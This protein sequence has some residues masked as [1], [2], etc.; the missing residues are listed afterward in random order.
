M[1]LFIT[2]FLWLIASLNNVWAAQQ[3]HSIILA[4]GPLEINLT[5]SMQWLETN[6]RNFSLGQLQIDG[7]P[8]FNNLTKS[9]VMT[10]KTSYWLR[11]HIINPLNQI[12]PVALSLSSNHVFI[13]GAYLYRDNQW[14][15]LVGFEKKTRLAGHTAITLNIQSHSNQWIYLRV[16]SPQSS[17]LDPKL[18]D[19]SHYNLSLSSLQQI[20]GGIIAFMLFIAL[21]HVIAIRFHNHIRHYLIIYIA[22][23]NGTYGLS[24]LPL[25]QWNNWF[26]LVCNLAPWTLACGLLLSSF[27]TH[28][29]RDWLKTNRTLFMLLGMSLVSL[30][31]FN[32]PQ[33]FVLFSS[34]IAAISAF[35]LSLKVS[36]NLSISIGIFTSYMAWQCLSFLFPQTLSPPDE[37]LHSYAFSICIMFCSTSMILP[38]FKRQIRK[39]IPNNNSQQSEFLA[40]LSH[41]LRSPM[42]GVLG[43]SELL[44]DTP[45]SHSQRDYVETIQVSGQ[46]ILRLINRISDFS[47]ISQGN[48]VLDEAPLN[49]STLLDGCTNKFAY[50]A[51]QK[52]IELIL[53]Q[54]PDIPPFILADERRLQT[55]IENLLENALLHTH[56][57]EIELRIDFDKQQQHF[58]LFS[59]RDTGNGI[60]K[61][62]LK[63]LFSS[64]DNLQADKSNLQNSGFILALCKRLVSLMGG[65]MYIDSKMGVGSTFSFSIPLK[66]AKAEKIQIQPKSQHQILNGLSMLVVDDNSTLRKVIQRYGKSWGMQIDSTYSG[67]EA[68]AMLRSK[69]NVGQAYDIILID[70][71]MPIMDGLQLAKRIQEDSEIDQGLLKIM[72]T[73]L[74]INS[75]NSDVIQSG[76]Q[77]V[78]NKP[79]SVHALQATLSEHISRQRRLKN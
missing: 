75:H 3:Q 77:Q 54:A 14:Q 59:I 37:M 42:N 50:N 66:Q 71:N 72:L 4:D 47:T 26:L 56:H 43:M 67:K 1:R 15:R 68:L 40:H 2:I 5:N 30:L 32:A 58:L 61:E 25:E 28:A 27:T 62:T 52:S 65:H 55:I 41:E 8:L 6:H 45:L 13:E 70:Q 11:F 44:N 79:V 46:D 24:N 33:E 20:Q 39:N 53:N 9:P 57:G 76:I 36:L 10:A 29:Y 18:Q 17:Q 64:M 23:I 38:Y 48:L 63:N 69:T 7:G 51:K 78:I 16:N 34:F 19:L 60:P 49:L 73:G 22:A 35:I 74:G 21:L 12:L 31:L